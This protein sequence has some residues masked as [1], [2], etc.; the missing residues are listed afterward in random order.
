MP[1]GASGFA[2]DRQLEGS[3]SRSADAI[4]FVF[5]FRTFVRLRKSAKV[6]RQSTDG[7]VGQSS[8]STTADCGDEDFW[9][10]PDDAG[11]DRLWK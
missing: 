2:R 7:G 8:S 4:S 6:R 3:P 10:G 5:F 1:C 11:I 9:V